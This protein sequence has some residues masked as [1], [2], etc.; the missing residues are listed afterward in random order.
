[1][2]MRH[3]LIKYVLFAYISKTEMWPHINTYMC[4][5]EV[6]FPLL[7]LR[8]NALNLIHVHIRLML[9]APVYNRHKVCISFQPVFHYVITY[10]THLGVLRLG[11][12][13]KNWMKWTFKSKRMHIKYI[14]ATFWA[15]NAVLLEKST[16]LTSYVN[17]NRSCVYCR[18]CL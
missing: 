3:H 11:S 15:D 12:G 16:A 2:Q 8:R 13:Q 6:F 10:K 7:P 9:P 18:V 14:Q 5:L 1:M 4:I 17:I